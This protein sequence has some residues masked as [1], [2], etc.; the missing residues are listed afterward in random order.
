[1]TLYSPFWSK[2]V[3]F[4]LMKNIMLVAKLAR[5]CGCLFLVHLF[6]KPFKVGSRLV[7]HYK[8]ISYITINLLIP[9][10][11]SPNDEIDEASLNYIFVLL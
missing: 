3:Y 2:C 1:M 4:S 11:S 5:F 8:L 7:I 9:V 6:K 10:Q